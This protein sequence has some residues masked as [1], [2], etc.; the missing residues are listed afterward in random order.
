RSARGAEAPPAVLVRGATAPSPPTRIP[1]SCASSTRTSAAS[2]VSV[3]SA[4][5]APTTPASSTTAPA[6][7]APTPAAA[8]EQAGPGG[9][10][11]AIR[12]SA[13]RIPSPAGWT[14]H[15]R[16]AR[17]TQRSSAEP[18]HRSRSTSGTRKVVPH[19]DQL[20]V[21]RHRHRPHH[22]CTDLID[23]RYRESGTSR[24]PTARAQAPTPSTPPLHR[25]DRR[26]VPERWY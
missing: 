9:S 21:H 23:V 26:Q 15:L 24:R 19:V 8:P 2:V 14:G 18:S 13:R 4:A 12:A 22:R 11:A 7:A 5:K 3:A 25:A 6:T 17:P 20:H 10:A 16:S 1:S